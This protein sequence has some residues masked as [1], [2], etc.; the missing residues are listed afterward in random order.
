MFE[1]RSRLV[2]ALPM[3]TDQF[4]ILGILLAAVAMFLWGRWRYDMVAGGALLACVL[5]GLVAPTEAFNGFSHAAVI[6]VA[7]VLVLSRGLQ[8]SGAIDVLAR[9][10]APRI[11]ALGDM[12][13]VGERGAEFHREIGEYARTRQIDALYAVGSLTQEA[14]AAFGGGTHFNDVDS[15]I[16]ALSSRLEPTATVLIKGSRF[17]RMERVVAALAATSEERGER[18]EGANP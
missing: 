15:L 14:V 16:A 12:G 17:M 18:R 3:T 11:L 2:H 13:E 10:P 9:A 4:L 8:M 1:R 5:T 7:C 6:T